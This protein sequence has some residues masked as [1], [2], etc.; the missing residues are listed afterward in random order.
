MNSEINDSAHTNIKGSCLCGAV[1]YEVTAAPAMAGFCC[2][3]SCRKLSGSGHA[4]HALV[5]ETAMK[6]S[7]NVRGFEWEADSGNTVVTSFCPTC[8]SPLFGKSSGM[9]GMVTFR[10]ASLDTPEAVSPQMAVYTKRLLAWDHLDPALPAFQE[11]PPL[12]QEG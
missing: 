12:P 10:V 3:E 4:F 6:V 11:M 2:C 5:P 7:G 9:P 8:G 1:R